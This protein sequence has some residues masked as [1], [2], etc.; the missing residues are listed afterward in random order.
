MNSMGMDQQTQWERLR[1]LNGRLPTND[2]ELEHIKVLASKLLPVHPFKRGRKTILYT[3]ASSEGLGMVL[4][5]QK[6]DEN[7]LLFI[8]AASTGLK[9][10]HRRY[11]TFELEMLGVVWA[12]KKVKVYLFGGHPILV[13]TDHASL[14]GIET[15]P[16]DPY[17][18]YRTQRHLEDILS[19]NIE[20]KHVSKANNAIADY[21]S[22]KQAMELKVQNM[23]QD[24]TNNG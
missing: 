14:A 19:F 6:E 11:S 22:Q 3:D 1:T 10:S 21:L 4:M 17:A 24:A 2:V 20:I 8:L 16:L 18:P 12:L 5:Q 13:Y 23:S 15:R 7:K 9:D